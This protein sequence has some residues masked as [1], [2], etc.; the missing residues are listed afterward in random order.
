MKIYRGR[1]MTKIHP[2]LISALDKYER[3]ASCSTCCMVGEKNPN[4]NWRL[5]GTQSW[6]GHGGEEKNS[7]HCQE[8]NLNH[9]SYLKQFYQCS[10]PEPL[11]KGVMAAGKGGLP[12]V[13]L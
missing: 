11:S 12:F 10:Y 1:G 6:Y 3:S 5:G 9:P 2:F 13:L 4:T 7:C 8:L